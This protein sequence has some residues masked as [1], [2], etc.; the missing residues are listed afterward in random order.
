MSAKELVFRA[1]EALLHRVPFVVHRQSQ[2]SLVATGP[3]TLADTLVRDAD[4]A[5]RDWWRST[6]DD[7]LN[8]R[9]T[10][11]GRNRDDVPPEWDLDPGSGERWPKEPA[12]KLRVTERPGFGDVKEAWEVNRLQYL[13]PIACH[14]YCEQDPDAAQLVATHVKSWLDQDRLGRGIA[15]KSAIEPALRAISLIVL[16]ELMSGIGDGSSGVN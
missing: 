7:V 6:Y 16:M 4:A 8:G 9:M 5:R 1:G 11:L 14:A 3:H 12:P 15:W 13:I 2:I 10:I